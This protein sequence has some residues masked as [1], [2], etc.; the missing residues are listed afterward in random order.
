M[1]GLAVLCPFIMAVD[2]AIARGDAS[3]RNAGNYVSPTLFGSAGGVS[4]SVREA[5]SSIGMIAPGT[6]PALHLTPV[7]HAPAAIVAVRIPA[8]VAFGEDQRSGADG[9]R[10]PDWRGRDDDGQSENAANHLVGSLE[11]K[12][13]LIGGRTPRVKPWLAADTGVAR[14]HYFVI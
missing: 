9:G 13:H 14:A 2:W 12:G 3:P 6:F 1:H 11:L 10:S 4:S 7:G 8:A 5:A